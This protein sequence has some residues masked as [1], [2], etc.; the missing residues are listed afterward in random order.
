MQ[1]LVDNS[2]QAMN[3]TKI[4]IVMLAAWILPLVGFPLGTIGLIF[5]LIGLNSSR[6]DL[7][8]SG[9][10]LNGLGLGLSTM[11]IIVSLYLLLSGQINPYDLFQ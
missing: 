1:Q 2:R 9:I 8:R 11:N 6:R 3:S 5:G 7:A 10:F 4:G